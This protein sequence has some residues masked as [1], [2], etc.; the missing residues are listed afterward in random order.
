[1]DCS[2]RLDC[3]GAL[4]K[5]GLSGGQTLGCCRDC[6]DEKENGDGELIEYMF[7]DGTIAEV[8]C[9]VWH[10]IRNEPEPIDG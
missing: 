1:M 6:H 9:W 4:L 2:S 3:K 7:Q 8:C 5:A 10:F